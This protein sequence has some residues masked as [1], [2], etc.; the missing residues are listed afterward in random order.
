MDAGL[1]IRSVD[2]LNAETRIPDLAGGAVMPSRHFYLRDHFPIPELDGERYRLSVGGL[3]ERPLAVSLE[4]A[5]QHAVREP[6]GDAGVRR[7]WPQPL[8]PAV[9]GEPWGLGAVGTAEWTGVPLTALL[10]RAGVQPGATEVVF[11]GADGGAV[12]GVDEPI[13]FERSLPLDQIR[14]T[15][16]LLAYA[17]NGEPLSAPHGYPLRLIVPGWYAVASVKWLTESSSPT[18]RSTATFRPPNIGTNG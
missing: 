12:A 10:D 2:P 17:M 14:E 4:R 7:Q 11:R 3:V 6:G 16:A 13:R 9:P 8:R 18:G 1:V 15:G 5:S